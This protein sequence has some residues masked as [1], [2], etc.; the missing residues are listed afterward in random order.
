MV[1]MQTERQS[2]KGWA[3]ML[4]VSLKAVL[5]FALCNTIYA[6]IQPLD[7]L[8]QITLYRGVFPL[9]PRIT[10]S[11]DADRLF[12]G[13]IYNIPA[14]MLRHSITAP[15]PEGEFRIIMLGDSATRGLGQTVEQTYAGRINAMNLQ[16]ADGRQ[17]VIYNLGLRS[18]SVL[19]DVLLLDYVLDTDPDM[20][21][22]MMSLDGLHQGFAL[23]HPFLERNPER[24]RDYIRRENLDLPLPPETSFLAR[25]I[26]GQR[27]D[28]AELLQLQTY[29]F[30]LAATT[31]PERHVPPNDLDNFARD[32]TWQDITPP[33][34]LTEDVL[35]LDVIEAVQQHV[36]VLLVN[37]PIY[38][39]SGVN[40][41]VRYNL[42]YPRWVYDQYR[43]LMQDYT[44]AQGWDY[45][46]LWDVVPPELFTDSA[47]H[48]RSSAA[49]YVADGIAAALRPL[50][51][52]Y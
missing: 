31:L 5:L 19:K 12:E 35:L 17:T 26:L 43:A 50:L 49:E 21:I 44:T 36:P 45:V 29:G 14:M 48:M 23:S 39:S 25:T 13:G 2:I 3:F 11:E 20:V 33:Y 6:L 7:T 16:T 9:Q 4:R 47:Y 46:D 30:S 32:E 18:N 28:L 22:W 37:Q 8:A 51:N 42:T 38:R 34:I 52:D 10:L 24:L 15:K 27:R 40:G 1:E 41:D